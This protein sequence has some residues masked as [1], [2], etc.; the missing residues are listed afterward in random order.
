MIILCVCTG[1]G[2]AYTFG[3]ECSDFKVS[4]RH[5]AGGGDL[6]LLVLSLI[7]ISNIVSPIL[8]TLTL[9]TERGSLNIVDKELNVTRVQ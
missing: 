4:K 9:N 1:G 3:S 5:G 8:L 7:H 2:E 6:H